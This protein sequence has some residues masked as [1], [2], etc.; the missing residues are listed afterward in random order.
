MKKIDKIMREKDDL[1]NNIVSK[2]GARDGYEIEK[3]VVLN[4]SFLKEHF[5][6][7]GE[8]LILLLSKSVFELSISSAFTITDF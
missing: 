1:E 3:G 2:R 8:A 4:E 7:I 5:D 6:E